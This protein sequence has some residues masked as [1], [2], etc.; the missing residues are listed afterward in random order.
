MYRSRRLRLP[1]LLASLPLVLAVPL[2]T[3]CATG[4]PEPVVPPRAAAQAAV[5]AADLAGLPP[6]LDRNLFFDDPRISGAQI[7]PD[8]EH[9]SF[10]KPYRDVL[11]LWVK[12]TG[13]P[14]EAA[15][16]ITADTERPV[17]GYFWS[18]DSRYVLYVQDKGGNEDFHVYAVDPAAPPEAETGVPAARNLTPFDGVRAMLYAVPKGT[19]EK[20]IVGLNDRDPALHDVYRV[21]LDTGER[22]LM[23]R[24]EQSVGIWV[25]DLGGEVR[26]AWRQTPDGGSEMLRVV[27]GALGEAV[28]TC[29]FEETC[30]PVRFH[31][32]G[33]RVYL[34][35]DRGDEVDLSRLLLL[36]PETGTTELVESDPE[37]EVDFAS[38]LFSER[39]DELIATF[40]IG[41][42]VRIY[43]R[44]EEL[45]R[46]L[47]Y[48]R[49]N[50]PDGELGFASV[51][52][53]DRRLLV[54][55]TRDVDPGTVYFHD[56]ETGAIEQLYRS[57]PELPT[58]HLAPMQPV[59][60]RA[61]DGQEIP[62]YLTLPV[63]V[64]ARRLPAVIVP[65]GGPWAR[66]FWGYNSFAQ[67]L[68]NRGYAVL[69]PN[70]R[71]SEGYGKR[72]LN[73]GNLEWGTGIMQ[74]DL[75]DGV[76]YLIE[77]GIADPERV[78]IMGAS[79]GGY[80]TLAG[81]TFTPELYAAGVSIVGPS[82][83]FTLLASIPPYWGPIK[84][85]FLKRM[86][87]SDDPAQRAMLEAQSPYFHAERIRVPLL[88]IQGANDPRVKKSE[89]DQ[90]VVALRDLGRDVEYVVAPDEGHG[91]A[92]REN[93]LA[94]TARIEEFLAQRL[95]GRHQE[96][97]EPEVRER[98]AAMTVDVTTV[99]LPHQAGEADVARTAPLPVPA[100]DGLRSGTL[101]YRTELAL[102]DGQRVTFESRRTLSRDALDG[103]DAWRVESS[104]EGQMGAASDVFWLHPSTLRPLHRSARQGGATIEVAFADRSV[105]GTLQAGGQKIPLEVDLEA[106]AYGDQGAL[107]VVIAAL[108]LV[109][110][111]RTT[112]RTVEI[113]MAQRVRLWALQVREE[114]SV[115][116]PAGSFDAFEIALEPLDGEGGGGTLWV[117]SDSRTL[118]R[119]E[120]VLPPAMGGGTATV[121]LL[122]ED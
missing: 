29:N 5:P 23:V 59:R 92:G 109:P 16:P 19:P 77:E 81:L 119:S 67:F 74:H 96:G 91:F 93:R 50:L 111:Y 33:R 105:T 115:T 14:F 9:I 100:T 103:V 36:D 82:N 104:M 28:Y 65:H 110:G 17:R 83:L 107:E 30:F 1:G 49:A 112:L 44:D 24:N 90:I 38:A 2:L 37:G 42:R 6:L 39:T 12:R 21:D 56:R 64:E 22:E 122:G 26:L 57:R 101:R 20:I 76:R 116:V 51:T 88:V 113:G 63:G 53:D 55:V 34:Q 40:Y 60:Y 47:E 98:L 73:A 7:S 43:P 114:G 70:F 94:M 121:E 108:P 18:R 48:L 25:T 61:R 99:E 15:R 68:A 35:S 89:S 58:E 31:H 120:L 87:D 41:N 4:A 11:N 10:R 71:G 106:P 13:E 52:A 72:F 117:S 85:I 27:D 66:D 95:G 86:G 46:T 102:G 69:Q 75:T 54:S 62:A 8:G 32:D 3:S 97:V 45:A 84:Q 80:A 118:V 78:A 79:Y